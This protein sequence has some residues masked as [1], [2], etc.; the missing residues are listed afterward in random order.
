MPN[1]VAAPKRKALDIAYLPFWTVKLVQNGEAD[2]PW[3]VCSM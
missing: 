1:P 3:G 2:Y